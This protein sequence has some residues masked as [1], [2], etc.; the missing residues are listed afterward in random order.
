MNNNEVIKSL[1]NL[2]QIGPNQD[3]AVSARANLINHIE[4][5]RPTA[6]N[7]QPTRWFSVSLPT[8]VFF[9]FS[10]AL[11][12]FVVIFGSVTLS[13]N[14]G[15]VFEDFDIIKIPSVATTNNIQI[16]QPTSLVSKNS[17]EKS[18]GPGESLQNEQNDTYASIR[19]YDQFDIGLAAKT[20][21]RER[22]NRV[23]VLGLESKDPY[24]TELANEADGL[25]Q[26]G[27]YDAALRVI[28]AAE[29]LL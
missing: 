16:Q 14:F 7:L 21:L 1:R 22:I 6:H 13:M 17:A 15:V 11:A 20:A 4:S 28:T 25:Y 24:I 5:T 9:A 3:W 23:S 18:T 19:A 8:P 26:E 27:D 2:R 12:L 29:S 10:G